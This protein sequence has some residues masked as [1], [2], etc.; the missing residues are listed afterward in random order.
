[1]QE[2]KRPGLLPCRDIEEEAIGDLDRTQQA[3][4]SHEY[5][6]YGIDGHIKGIMV[7]VFCVHH[8]LTGQDEHKKV[9]HCQ[10]EHRDRGKC[11]LESNLEVSFAGAE[12]DP[13]LVLRCLMLRFAF[14]KVC[15]GAAF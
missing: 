11:L 14:A 7:D 8:A 3:K 4:K 6:G 9:C 2:L 10:A 12:V 5:E 15:L 13:V 1:M